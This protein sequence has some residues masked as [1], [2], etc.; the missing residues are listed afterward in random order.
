MELRGHRYR[1]F[2][3][4]NELAG[5]RQEDDAV[6]DAT[7]AWIRE[8]LDADLIDGVRVDHPD[9][10]WD[11]MSYL[12]RLRG[13]IGTDRLLYIEKILAADEAL[14]P[15]LPVEGTTGYDQLRL[16]ESV[17]TA[18]SGIVELSEIHEHTTGV[19]ADA[20]GCT[21]PNGSAS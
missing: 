13:D 15:T 10:L 2:F 4:V 9:G 17:F 11:P 3:T 18:P 16:I 21:T 14:E 1:R 19:P 5:L 20:T 6:Y 12:E 7:H 8:L